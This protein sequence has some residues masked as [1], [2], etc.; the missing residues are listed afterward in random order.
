MMLAVEEGEVDKCRRA[1]DGIYSIETRYV[2]SRAQWKRHAAEG[3]HGSAVV[4]V[5]FYEDILAHTRTI[6]RRR[7]AV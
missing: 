2:T 1:S 6:F 7:I 3:A 4:M 5:V